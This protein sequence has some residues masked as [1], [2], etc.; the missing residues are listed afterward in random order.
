MRTCQIITDGETALGFRLAGVEAFG[1]ADGKET[2]QV[3]VGILERRECGLLLVR[4]D[5]LE[6]VAAAVTRRFEREGLPIVIPLPVMGT[7]QEEERGLEYVLRLI[8][9][10]I[11]YSMRIR[12]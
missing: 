5:F 6:G 10:S 1:A 4:E 8:R 2:E 12:G 9:R 3:M 7:W 11:G